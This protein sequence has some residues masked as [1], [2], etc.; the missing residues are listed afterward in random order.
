[1]YLRGRGLR[2]QH[3]KQSAGVDRAW[4]EHV[5]TFKSAPGGWKHSG[6]KLPSTETASAT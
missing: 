3:G 4:I 2:Y 6:K 5:A 1:M